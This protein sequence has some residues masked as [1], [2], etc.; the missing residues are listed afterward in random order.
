M[1]GATDTIPAAQWD[2]L[3]SAAREIARMKHPSI[4]HILRHR[5]FAF[6]AD[7]MVELVMAI[8]AIDRTAR[9]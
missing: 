4:E 9:E 3:L 7:R 1:S 5:G 6:E 2:A 8:K